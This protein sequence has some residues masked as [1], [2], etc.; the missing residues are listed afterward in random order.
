MVAPIHHIEDSHI[1]VDTVNKLMSGEFSLYIVGA[2]RYQDVFS[3]IIT[4]YETPY[5]FQFNKKG[6]PLAECPFGGD[7]H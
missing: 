2:T 7:I 4:P 6:Q 5:C 1:T 3:P